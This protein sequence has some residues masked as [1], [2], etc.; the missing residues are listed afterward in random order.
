M[1]KTWHEYFCYIHYVHAT[2]GECS[3][4][5]LNNDHSSYDNDHD[6]HRIPMEH[7]R[8]FYSLI[9]GALPSTSKDWNNYW[10]YVWMHRWKPTETHAFF[11]EK[12]DHLSCETWTQYPGFTA[13]NNDFSSALKMDRRFSFSKVRIAL[14]AS[15]LQQVG[16]PLYKHCFEQFDVNCLCGFNSDDPR[17]VHLLVGEF[18]HA[19]KVLV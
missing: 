12:L 14:P 9:G 19:R 10:Y 11:F 15:R 18:H 1:F 7:N 13:I 8:G 16:F 2:F 17:D 3:Y 4:I 6:F 5:S